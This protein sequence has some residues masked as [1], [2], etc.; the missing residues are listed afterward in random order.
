M[1]CGPTLRKLFSCKKT[2]S[3]GLC[4]LGQH[5]TSN[6]LVQLCLRRI[7]LKHSRHNIGQQKPYTMYCPRQH[8]TDSRGK[9]SAMLSEHHL[10]I[11]QG[12]FFWTGYFFDINRLLPIPHQYCSNLI[13]IG[14]EKSW[15]N[16]DQKD[17]IVRNRSFM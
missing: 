14:Q 12:F 15:V 1:D 2:V 7:C 6:F 16:I 11:F 5:C 17:K 8:Y 9:S 10:V 3:A 4:T 13:D